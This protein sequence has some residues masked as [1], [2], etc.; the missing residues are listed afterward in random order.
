MS[1]LYSEDTS[2][3]GHLPWSRRCPL[4]RGSTIL[5]RRLGQSD[6]IGCWS[7]V[8]NFCELCFFVATDFET[9]NFR[10]RLTKFR[11]SDKHAF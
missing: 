4:N 2:I 10:I 8:R 11:G 1:N 5:V 3:W 7:M 6:L 9:V